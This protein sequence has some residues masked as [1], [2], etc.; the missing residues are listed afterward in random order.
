MDTP[1]LHEQVEETC[2]NAWPALKEVFYDGWLIRLANGAT[3]RINSVNVIGPGRRPLAEKIAYCE[4]IYR[5]HGR[6]SY[7]RLL[8]T[9]PPDLDAALAARGYAKEDETKTL[10]MNFARRRPPKPAP[11]VAVDIR[12]GRAPAEWLAAYRRLSRC[13]AKEAQG[14]REVLDMLVVPAFFGEARDASG[15]IAS[16]AFCGL[17]GDLACLQWVVTDPDQRRMGFSR[18]TLS[19]LLNRALDAGARGACLQVVAANAPAIALYKRLG[20]TCELYRY[21]YRVR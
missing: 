19:A 10:F 3:R 9:A 7:F 16:V 20:F 11:D 15:E 17:H 12:E 2:R 8:S 4:A 1:P 5:A 14:R 18:A 21:H 6:P 13:G